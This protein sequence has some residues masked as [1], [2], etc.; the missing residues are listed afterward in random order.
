MGLSIVFGMFV[1]NAKIYL[2]YLRDINTDVLW[3][4]SCFLHFKGAWRH[5]MLLVSKLNVSY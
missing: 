5:K 3:R 4:F 1:G 2:R